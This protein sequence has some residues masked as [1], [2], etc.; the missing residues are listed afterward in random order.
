MKRLLVFGLGAL[1]A[2][3]GLQVPVP[4]GAAVTTAGDLVFSDKA[5]NGDLYL[6][7]E[8]GSGLRRL[9]WTGDA[10]NPAWSPDSRTVA[11]DH[12]GD[13]WLLTL[14]VGKHRL[15]F[16]GRSFDPAWSPDGT[17]I[18]YSRVVRSDLRDIF[19]VPTGGGTSTRVSFAARSGCTASQPAWRPNG[20]QVA[21]VRVHATNGSCSEGIVLQSPGLP[22]HVVVADPTAREPDFTTNGDDL[23]FLA[24]C[25]PQQCANEGGWETTATGA[26]RHMIVN[27]YNCVES[28]L[29]LTGLIARPSGGWVSAANVNDPTTIVTCYQGGIEDSAGVIT[30][31]QPSV[32]IGVLGYQFDMRP[33]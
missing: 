6:V 19:V 17:K 22:G 11:Y 27:Q 7:H 33:G 20:S 23:V 13:I 1:I 4:A 18:A 12:A 32:C 26:D 28:N 24:P 25:D 30:Q 2:A 9:T 31:T 3:L 14:G 5:E 15:T 10:N 8:D 21:Y 29:C 16:N